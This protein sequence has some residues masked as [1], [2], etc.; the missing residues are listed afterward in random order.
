MQDGIYHGSRLTHISETASHDK[1]APVHLCLVRRWS[2]PWQTFLDEPI[3]CG[4]WIRLVAVHC[5]LWTAPF[6]RV[7]MCEELTVMIVRVL[8]VQRSQWLEY[9]LV[10]TQFVQNNEMSE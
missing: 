10:R 2:S 7:Q 8:R 5:Q 6:R 4:I 3:P 1:T 9:V